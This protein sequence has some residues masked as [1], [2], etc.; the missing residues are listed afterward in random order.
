MFF[1]PAEQKM[2][3]QFQK[4]EWVV[5]GCDPD[6]ENQHGEFDSFKQ[7]L[8]KLGYS[9][10]PVLKAKRDVFFKDD[11]EPQ[12][13]VDWLQCDGESVW[14]DGSMGHDDEYFFTFEDAIQ[15]A[16]ELGCEAITKT[17]NGYVVRQISIP[18]QGVKMDSILSWTKKVDY[19]PKHSRTTPVIDSKT[20]VEYYNENKDSHIEYLL[21]RQRNPD[22]DPEPEQ[23][24]QPITD[25]SYYGMHDAP[26]GNQNPES[27]RDNEGDVLCVGDKK[28]FR[29]SWC[30]LNPWFETKLMALGLLDENGYKK[31]PVEL[32]NG[33]LRQLLIDYKTYC[34]SSD[35]MLDYLSINIDYLIHSP[36]R[37]KQAWMA[38]STKKGDV[39]YV[40]GKKGMLKEG[41][42]FE[43]QDS[44][45]INYI[46]TLKYG[47]KWISTKTFKVI[48]KVSNEVY[49]S[50]YAKRASM[51]ELNQN[52]IALLQ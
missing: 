47:D 23:R 48:K 22:P 1:T 52:E 13:F 51:W 16:N 50:I 39:V 24:T 36:I 37:L 8:T 9:M 12:V 11:I 29:L 7:L 32:Q 46:K 43:V 21:Q 45:K 41:W 40:R 18:I 26:G 5:I 33:S 30:F 6:C 4:D 2:I 49:E 10:D 31:N 44:S 19:T 14:C 34:E 42:L 20:A 17:I 3:T 25:I 27:F 35:D 15:R 38:I 28:E